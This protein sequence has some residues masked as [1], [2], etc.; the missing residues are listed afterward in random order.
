M[1]IKNPFSGLV[2][3]IEK[4]VVEK[5]GHS[6]MGQDIVDGFNSAVAYVWTEE[7]TTKVFE[8]TPVEKE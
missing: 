1:A 7:E 8:V 4:T 5:A 2:T 3:L 6:P